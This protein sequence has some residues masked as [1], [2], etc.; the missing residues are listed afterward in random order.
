MKRPPTGHI[1]PPS[2]AQMFDD[3]VCEVC[4]LAKS[5]VEVHRLSC[6]CCIKG[7]LSCVNLWLTIPGN[8]CIVCRNATI[9]LHDNVV[10]A[11]SPLKKIQIL[12]ISIPSEVTES[13]AKS[14]LFEPG[15]LSYAPYDDE[16]SPDAA[17]LQRQTVVV[18]Y[19]IF[20][21]RDCIMCTIIASLLAAFVYIIYII[22]KG[23]NN[24]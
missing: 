9:Y 20:L 17:I 21:K 7:H 8:G 4:F 24:Q 3:L 13:R 22:V 14:W 11:G 6:G 19:R 23:P 10:R 18:T 5:P 1:L 2:R 15:Y 12:R 16:P